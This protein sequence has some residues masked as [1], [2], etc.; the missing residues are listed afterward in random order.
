MDPKIVA[1]VMVW[2]SFLIL[3]GLI[4]YGVA[5]SLINENKAKKLRLTLKA[6][7]VVEIH[8]TTGAPII[9]TVIEIKNDNLKS[10][11]VYITTTMDKIY[12]V[13]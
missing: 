7:D 2:G 8:Q 1:A 10:V 5:K 4:V 6:G 11:V 12:P 9:G 13:R 3:L